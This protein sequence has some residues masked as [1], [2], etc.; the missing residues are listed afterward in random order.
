MTFRLEATRA[1]RRRRVW[2]HLCWW[3]MEVQTFQIQSFRR[4]G[5]AIFVQSHYQCLALGIFWIR[6][7]EISR[8]G[9]MRPSLETVFRFTVAERC[10]QEFTLREERLVVY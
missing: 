6:S 8:V 7:R 1:A 10:M 4:E 5:S 9:G 2:G 3:R